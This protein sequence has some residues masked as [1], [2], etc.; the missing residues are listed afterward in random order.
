MS[1][2]PTDTPASSL[3]TTAGASDTRATIDTG[4]RDAASVPSVL[5]TSAIVN[6]RGPHT[7]GHEIN[8]IPGAWRGPPSSTSSDEFNDTITNSANT[9]AIPAPYADYRS[10][11]PRALLL[12]T[13]LQKFLAVCDENVPIPD[14]SKA[15]LLEIIALFHPG[16]RLNLETLEEKLLALF[17]LLVRPY[18]EAMEEFDEANSVMY[19]WDSGTL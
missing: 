12:E 8:K 3:I 13:H 5:S 10:S 14:A 2:P 18:F 7:N 6:G 17:Q 19:F 11:R 9:S 4:E 15:E 1:R 16:L